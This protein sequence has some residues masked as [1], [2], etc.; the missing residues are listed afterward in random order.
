MRQA[1]LT[2]AQRWCERDEHE[3]GGNDCGRSKR[4]RYEWAGKL[5]GNG[6]AIDLTHRMRFTLEGQ[7]AV[8][9][10]RTAPECAETDRSA[11]CAFRRG[12]TLSPRLKHSEGS[13][14]PRSQGKTLIAGEFHRPGPGDHDQLATGDRDG[15]GRGCCRTQK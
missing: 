12:Y 13:I 8:A 9:D 15:V 4:R 11:R 14:H 1:E 6:G 10:V 7:Y 2:S 3:R 5:D